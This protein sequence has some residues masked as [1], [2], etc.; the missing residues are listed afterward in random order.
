MATRPESSSAP[1]SAPNGSVLYLDTSALTKLY[2]DESGS[3]ELREWIGS[4]EHG[5]DPGIRLYTSR[6]GVPET[7]SAITRRR[8]TGTLPRR[9]SIRN[10]WHRVVSDFAAPV[11]PYV[12]IDVSEVVV[13]RAAWLVAEH[14]LRAYDAVH[15]ASAMW[16]QPRLANPDSLVFVCADKQLSEVAGAVRLTTADPTPAQA[17]APRE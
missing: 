4:P 15:L 5:F 14:G 17:P 2:V 9:T 6:I 10:L 11:P 13:G 16:L 8:N 7:V 1:N 12:V 3:N